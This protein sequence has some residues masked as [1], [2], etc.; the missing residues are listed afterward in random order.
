MKGGRWELSG[1]LGIV[2]RLELDSL[3]E[4]ALHAQSCAQ[5][6]EALLRVFRAD[7]S[8]KTERRIPEE[9]PRPPKMNAIR[10][11]SWF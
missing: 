1:P 8:L 9:P 4:A 6:E 3:R 7:G 2:D 5:G 10:P 11:S